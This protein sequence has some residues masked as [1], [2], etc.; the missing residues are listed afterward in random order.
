M[1]LPYCTQIPDS[2]IFAGNTAHI[3]TN[4][5][6][7]QS[8]PANFNCIYRITV[9]VNS[10]NGLYANVTLYNGLKGVND[11]IT[12]VEMTGYKTIMT[13][14]TGL[15][16]S[17]YRYIVVPGAVMTIQVTTKS[18]FMNS[19]FWIT[20]DY[21]NAKIG[22][23][24]P[25]KTGGEMNYF[26]LNS[27]R[28]G[29]NLFSSA[30]FIDTAPIFMAVAIQEDNVINCWDCFVID[31]T[32]ENQKKVYR[33]ANVDS[34][35]F[36]STSN[37]ITLISFT[38]GFVPFVFNPLYETDQF[39]AVWALA[40]RPGIPNESSLKSFFVGFT[41]AVEVVN[42]ESTG[43]ILTELEIY[44]SNCQALIVSGPPN[45]SSKILL[46]LSKKPKLPY[47]FD[48]KYFTVINENCNF[49]FGVMSYDN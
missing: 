15:G 20:V 8:I 31:G 23:T 5:S 49:M 7:L 39:K 18:V 16:G 47:S 17:P 46:D 3:P 41:E 26:D 38:D 40:T 21:G 36:T 25:L 45:N 11:Q 43:I 35:A 30:T 44:S 33:L 27:T 1:K 12:V 32:F 19:K 6:E 2:D 4:S 28:D 13:N 37:A 9:P 42:Y 10:T 34:T 24:N 22:A 29:V 14:R 48:L